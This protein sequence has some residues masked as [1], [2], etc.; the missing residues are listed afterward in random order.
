MNS[1]TPTQQTSLLGV[2]LGDGVEVKFTPNGIGSPIER[3]V[4][5]D[6]IQHTI[7]PQRHD[8]RFDFSQTL[9]SLVL[10]DT[11]QGVLDQNT[12]GF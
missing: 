1:L 2:E 8:V 10:N 7:S 9:A 6:Q 5:V 12:L 11:L 3:N 4:V